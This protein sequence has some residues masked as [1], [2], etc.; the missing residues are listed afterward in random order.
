MARKPPKPTEPLHQ[1][2]V[3]EGPEQPPEGELKGA[4]VPFY[5]IPTIPE[6]VQ[7]F[8]RGNVILYTVRG[9]PGQVQD[10][11]G[12]LNK[13]GVDEVVAL[14]SHEAGQEPEET[15]EIEEPPRDANH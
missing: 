10:L 13:E 5:G 2:P 9:E 7:A 4:L 3:P 15:E 11:M 8:R 6:G 12:R 14:I 1:E